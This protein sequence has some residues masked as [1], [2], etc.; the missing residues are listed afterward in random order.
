MS[1]GALPSSPAL[2]LS[3]HPDDAAFSVGGL[4][5]T[6]VL[7][8]VTIATVF[9]TTNYLGVHGFQADARQATAIR[10]AE[11]AAFAAAVGAELV[12]CGLP[13]ASVRLGPSLDVIFGDADGAVPAEL[14]AMLADVVRRVRPALILAPAALGG[15]VDHRAVR[16][17]APDLA[18]SCGAALAWY[19]DL[20]Y[21]GW[22][23]AD[24][25][26]AHF[27]TLPGDPRPID[28]PLDD[29]MAMKLSSIMLY[30]TQAMPDWV[31]AIRGHALRLH[32][33]G[34]E[35]LWADAGAGARLRS[36]MGPR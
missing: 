2:V 3:P 8:P 23:A 35:R 9:G 36:L 7:A 13:D 12:S 21:A 16:A 31:D 28:I 10:R 19:E 5:H 33:A 18:R 17:L 1:G 32:P 14:P 24:D 20:P 15:H 29:A 25:I 26:A 34:A 27:A 11:D 22:M 6:R 30:G 4:L